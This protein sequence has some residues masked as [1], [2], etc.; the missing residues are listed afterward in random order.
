MVPSRT[1]LHDGVGFGFVGTRESQSLIEYP[2]AR[3]DLH[4]TQL[5]RHAKTPGFIEKHGH[6]ARADASALVF[7]CEENLIELEA[8]VRLIKL[9][10]VT[11]FFYLSLPKKYP[12]TRVTTGKTNVVI[13]FNK[14]L[15]DSFISGH[16]RNNGIAGETTKTTAIPTRIRYIVIILFAINTLASASNF[17]LCASAS[18]S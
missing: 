8:V 2:G 13:R 3:V 5:D 12:I 16:G 1:P 14:K 15:A 17:C 7:R 6:A 11:R 18:R 4:H 10:G 9:S